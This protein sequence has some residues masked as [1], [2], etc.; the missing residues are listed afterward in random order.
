MKT[1]LIAL[2]AGLI[3]MIA[4]AQQLEDDDMYFNAADRKALAALKPSPKFYGSDLKDADD[5]LNPTDSYS[6]RG[7]NPQANAKGKQDAYFTPDY[8]PKGVNQ[9]NQNNS[10]NSN[11]YNYNNYNSCGN[12]FGS[13]YYNNGFSSY[14]SFGMGVGMSPWNS[15]YSPY[16]MGYY[17]PYAYNSYYGSPYGN[18]LYYSPYYSNPSA[19]YNRYYSQSSQDRKPK[20]DYDNPPTG[21]TRQ[22][23][24]N[25]NSDRASSNRATNTTDNVPP[26]QREYNG[27]QNNNW[28]QPSPQSGWGRSSGGFGGGGGLGGGGGNAGRGGR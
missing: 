24:V 13:P 5:E 16:G 22:R 23:V 3:P 8:T 12:H 20:F 10:R 18:S 28:S 1:K 4:L 15:Y 27:D 14:S 2:L 7:Q 19:Y 6:G 9:N 17:S 21:V 11:A 25:T 26:R